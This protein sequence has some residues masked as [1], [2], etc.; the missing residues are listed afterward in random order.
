MD[1]QQLAPLRLL[2]PGQILLHIIAATIVNQSDRLR[3]EADEYNYLPWAWAANLLSRR[4]KQAIQLLDVP[5]HLHGGL[6]DVQTGTVVWGG[7]VKGRKAG[8]H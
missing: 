4:R 1:Q 2:A 5:I 3:G 6:F 7:N 8:R